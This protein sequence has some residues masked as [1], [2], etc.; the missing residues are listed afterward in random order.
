MMTM[1]PRRFR[2]LVLTYHREYGR[3]D[4]PWR[5]T[6]D[7][8]R[9]LVSEIM[10]QQTQVERVVPFYLAFLKKFPTARAL[11]SAPLG[12]VLAAWQGLG[13]N[14]RA[15]MLHDTAKR[16]AAEHGGKVPTDIAALEALPGIGP[17]TARAV[18]AFAGNADTV[19]IETNIRTAVTHH[20]FNKKTKVVDRELLEVL[21]KAYPKG[22]A[23]EWYAALMD[24]GSFLKRSGVRLNARSAGYV[25]QAPFKGSVREVRGAILKALAGRRQSAAELLSL[26][27][28][29]REQLVAS[30]RK[31][32]AEG[33]VTKQGGE[34]RLP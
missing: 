22:R 20:F 28:D 29:R 24:Y 32:E 3:H 5:K 15:K 30:L 34:F 27:P 8:Y 12:E 33:L 10:L 14:R 25:R 2:D 7:P 18:A 31:L 26:L 11:A 17:Y 19:F 21:A 1:S 6:R 16:V 23:R 4:L 9:I 13:Y